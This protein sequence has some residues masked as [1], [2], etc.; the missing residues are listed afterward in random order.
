MKCD[1]ALRLELANLGGGFGS[2]A[3]AERHV[4][5]IE[6]NDPLILRGVLRDT[7]K[8][9]LQHMVAVQEG[10]LCRRLEPHFVLRVLRQVVEAS[11]VQAEFFRLCELSECTPQ[12]GQLVT[13]QCCC[14]LHLYG[15]AAA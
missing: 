11:D 2:G 9:G 12:R 4:G 7:A 13:R 3:E 6:N 5:H 1:D 10:L 8:P 14:M 15:R